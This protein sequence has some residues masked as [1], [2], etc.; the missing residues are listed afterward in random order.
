M[1]LLARPSGPGQGSTRCDYSS[2]SP[3]PSTANTH[4][5]LATCQCGHCQAITKRNEAIN[6]SVMMLTFISKY[7]SVAVFRV[8]R[9]TSTLTSRLA[10][11]SHV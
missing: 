8:P 4:A 11:P 5:K 3:P 1:N 10:G 6:V 9:T 2:G 7:A